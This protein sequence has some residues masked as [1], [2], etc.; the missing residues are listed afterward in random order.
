LVVCVAAGVVAVIAAVVVG[1]NSSP[2]DTEA[3]PIIGINNKHNPGMNF[4]IFIVSSQLPVI[5]DF[6]PGRAWSLPSSLRGF[7]DTG[8]PKKPALAPLFCSG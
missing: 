4:L 5:N 7:A 1:P 3:T 6:V 2:Q 8:G